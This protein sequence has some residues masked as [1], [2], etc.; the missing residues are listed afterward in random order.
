MEPERADGKKVWHVWYYDRNGGEDGKGRSTFREI[1][2]Y[3]EYVAK[4]IFW[5]EP[6]IKQITHMQPERI[7][8]MYVVPAKRNGLRTG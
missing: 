1:E 2:A 8:I 5:D 7:G 6:D 4:L 3:S